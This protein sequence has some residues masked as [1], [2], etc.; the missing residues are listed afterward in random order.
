MHGCADSGCS[1]TGVLSGSLHE[2][3]VSRT[4]PGP[5]DPPA[6]RLEDSKD[7]SR[8]KTHSGIDSSEVAQGCIVDML[9]RSGQEQTYF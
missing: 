7:M 2:E 1:H 6:A 9:S 5:I 4:G 3:T 8:A